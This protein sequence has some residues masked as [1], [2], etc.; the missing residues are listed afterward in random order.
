[1]SPGPPPSKASKL[2]GPR[3]QEAERRTAI[4]S[5]RGKHSA[6]DVKWMRVL[7]VH[8]CE[9][10]GFISGKGQIWN[11]SCHTAQALIPRPHPLTLC[12]FSPFLFCL[13]FVFLGPHP[14]HREVPRLGI[15][16]EL[17]LPA[18]A[19][20]TA[21]RDPSH[22]CDLHPSLRQCWILNPLIEAR[23]RTCN[24]TVPSQIR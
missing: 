9:L 18:Y 8:R 1:M 17:Q 23:D 2:Q 10:K 3:A 16:S 7:P 6:L 20:A 14:R 5:R 4:T 11:V 24:F 12:F 19:T 22:V 13:S 15:Q 21:T